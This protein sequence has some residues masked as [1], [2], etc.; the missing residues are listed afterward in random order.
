MTRQSRYLATRR[1]VYVA[2][3]KRHAKLL[4]K[5]KEQHGT[6]TRAIELALETAG[7]CKCKTQ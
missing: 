7:G 4:D 1:V 5:L 3:S 2:I 6:N